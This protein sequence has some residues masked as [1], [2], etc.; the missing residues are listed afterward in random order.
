[1]SAPVRFLVVAVAGW[2]LFRGATAGMLPG[3]EAFTIASAKAEAPPASSPI[4][5]TEFPPIAPVQPAPPSEYA[6]AGYP[7]YPPQYGQYPAAYYPAPPQPR[8]QRSVPSA[9]NLRR[10]A[11]PP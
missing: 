7:Q 11:S 4:V 1:M 5:P 6:Y 2:A 9:E 3:A 8:C 10:T